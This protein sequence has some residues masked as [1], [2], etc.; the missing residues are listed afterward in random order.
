MI[1]SRLPVVFGG[2]RRAS[3]GAL[4]GWLG[5]MLAAPL[6][7]ADDWGGLATISATMG[8]NDGHICIGEGSRN[9]IGCPNYGPYVSRTNG[10]VGFGTS[11]PNAELDVLAT[12]SST[13]ANIAGTININTSGPTRWAVIKRSETYLNSQPN[14]LVFSFNNG[15]RWTQT[16]DLTGAGQ[17]GVGV[18]QPS[19]S[20]QVRGSIRMSSE[21]SATL[22]TCDTN[23]TGAIKYQSGDFHYCRNGSNWESLT[24]LTGG[25]SFSDR[26]TSGT[27]SVIAN[28]SGGTVSFTLAGTLGRA[29]L[30]TNLGFV[31]PGISV[32]GVVSGS[33]GYFA[34]KLLL[35]SPSPTGYD[36]TVLKMANTNTVSDNANIYVKSA[37]RNAHIDFDAR[38]TAGSSLVFRSNETELGRISYSNGFNALQLWISATEQMRI[39][40]S[41]NVGIGTTVPNSKLDVAGT[42]SA[43]TLQLVDNPANPCNAANKGMAKVV[44]GR[45]YICRYP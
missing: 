43:T 19:N 41:G 6:A 25:G 30:H 27:A 23:R 17:V 20:L 33:E 35:G 9:D 26:I 42:V 18:S 2:P 3:L 11:S 40:S 44:D 28:Q 16:L 39:V 1:T 38:N 8:V 32:T 5:L 29:Y 10:F 12:V 45:V 37:N 31:G 4:A 34:S 22:Q 36:L 15:S 7:Y 14:N 21:A 13:T 24:S